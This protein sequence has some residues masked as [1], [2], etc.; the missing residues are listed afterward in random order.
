M[1][2]L[3][4]VQLRNMPAAGWQ[5]HGRFRAVDLQDN[6]CG[7]I[8]ALPDGCSDAQ[9]D[10][11]LEHKGDC[12]HLAGCWSISIRCTC[13]RCNGP[14]EHMLRGT[15]MR[16]FRMQDT[17]DADDDEDVLLPPGHI[18]LTDVL[19]EEIWL[20]WPQNVVCRPECKGLCPHCG[21]DLNRASCACTTDDEDHPFSALKNMKWAAK[22]SAG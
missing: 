14:A 17:A 3:L 5:W 1:G 4:Q 16:D 7:D 15:L 18:N 13:C 22:D 21:A 10:A 20:A 9:W 8:D 11:V 2:S 19:R 6:G 12:Y